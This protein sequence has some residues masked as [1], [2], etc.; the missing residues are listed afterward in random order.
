VFDKIKKNKILLGLLGLMFLVLVMRL[1]QVDDLFTFK[2]DQSRDVK[3][4][5]EAYNDGVGELPLLGPRAAKTYLR[6]GPIFYYFE[7]LSMW[8]TGNKTP[9]G[10]VWPDL[11]FSILVIP[12]FYYFLRQ[13]FSKKVSFLTTAVLTSSFFLNQYGRFAWNPNSIPFWSILLFLSTYKVVIGYQSTV[14]SLTENRGRRIDNQSWWL[15]VASLSYGVSSQLHFTAMLAYPAIIGL[16]V[17]I[18]KLIDWRSKEHENKPLS[19]GQQSAF[20]TNQQPRNRILHRV[21]R[22]S[23][24]RFEGCQPPP[25]K[26]ETLCCRYLPK[27]SGRS[28]PRPPVLPVGCFR[29]C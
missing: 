28:V 8:L 25:C 1:W 17:I 4:V 10:V 12:L 13:A 26:E 3:L 7:Y 16:F 6:L 23:S 9:L 2:M 14:H 18:I 5:E 27:C 22:M 24:E 21:F 29:W 20:H 15:L 11:I 19:R